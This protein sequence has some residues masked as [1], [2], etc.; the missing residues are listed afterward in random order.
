MTLSCS[1]KLSTLLRGITS[2]HHGDFYCLNCLHSFRIENKLKSR[3]KICKNKD[4]CG[5]VTPSEKD[6]ALEF[7]QHMKSDKMSYIIYADIESL[8]R[9]IDGCA[10]NLEKSSTTKKYEHVPFGYSMST[11]WGFDHIED[12]HTLYYG[13][14]CMKKICTSLR[15]HAKNII[16]FEKK[17]MLLSTKEELKSH[18]DAKGCYICGKRILRKFAK[19]K[20][21]RKVRDHCHYT[22]K[23]R[24]AAHSI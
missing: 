5:I 17:K 1:K 15:E 19:D 7:N 23:Y 20:N 16:D 2:K 12:K 24:G 11:I 14:D 9:K 3:E 13:K 18:Q 8:I 6:N 22:G 4:F 10:N 21:H